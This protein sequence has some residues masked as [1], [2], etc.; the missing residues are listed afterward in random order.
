MNEKVQKLLEIPQFVQRS[1]EWF[2]QRNNAITAS[3]IPTV[4]G[5]NKYK[6]A[7]SLL[8]DKCN[9]NPKPFTGNEATRWGT[10]YEDTAIEVYSKLKDKEVLSFGLLIHRDYPWLGGSPDGITKDGILLEVKCPMRRKIVEGECPEHYRSQVL[11]NL[12]ICDLE[13][14]N[15]IEYIPG[16]SDDD[17]QINIVEIKRDHQWFAEKVKIMKEFWDSVVKYREEGIETHPKWASYKKRSDTI[18]NNKRLK[19]EISDP[20]VTIDVKN[21]YGFLEEF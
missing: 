5:E 1:P 19:A 7:W 4:L 20:E 17:Y 13:V 11:L 2:E 8:M 16:K 15:Y 6:S 18:K 12:E 10:H 9:A 3:D 14:A 21:V